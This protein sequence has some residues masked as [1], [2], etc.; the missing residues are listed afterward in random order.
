MADT[1]PIAFPDGPRSDLEQTIEELIERAQR[2]LETQDR[3]RSLMRANTVVVEG[4]EL[5]EV[6]RRIVEAAVSLVDAQYGALGVVAPDGHLEQFIHVG[7]PD[8]TVAAIGQLPEGHGLLGAVIDSGEAIRLPHLGEDVRSA[9]FPRHHPAMDSFLGVPIRVRDEVYGNLYLTNREGG[10]FSAEDEDLVA[11]LAATA[12]IAIDNARL[13][14]ESERRR[15]WSAALTDVT[16]ALLSGSVDVLAVVADRAGS[17]VDADLVCV[18]VPAGEQGML[19]VRL[20]RGIGAADLERRTFAAADTL[21]GR[22]FAAD[23]ITTVDSDLAATEDWQPWAGPSIAL[24]LKAAGQLLGVLTLSR[25]P[26]AGRFLTTDLD[27]AAEFAAQA[28]VAIE[29]GRAR[30]DRQHLELVGERSRIARDLHDNVIQRLFGAGLSLQTVA[31]AAPAQAGLINAQVD[32]I[33]AAIADIR[34]AI[35]TLGPS[36]TTTTRHRILDIASEAASGLG[37]APRVTFVGPVDLLVTDLLADDVS[38]VVRETLSNVARHAHARAVSVEVSADEEKVVV[39]VDD[40]GDG[41]PPNPTRR[42]GT[43]NLAARAEARGGAFDLTR[44]ESGG[45]RATWIAVVDSDRV[46]P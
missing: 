10:S 22:A 35:F 25:Q 15:R 17:A 28:G 36:S 6:L 13:F 19:E 21:P 45:T 33:D 42:S 39:T 11:A 24:P 14:E 1:P 16:S 30:E 5:S 4:L 31:D 3:L 34:T 41:I 46:G 38:A 2:V 20:A 27:M 43:G 23:S 12:G 18:V 40:D 26:G 8:D 29:L 9:G 44:R 32:A 37:F 7:M